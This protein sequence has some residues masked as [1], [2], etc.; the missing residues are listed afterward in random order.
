MKKNILIFGGEFFNKGA[1]SMSFITISRLKDRFPDHEIIFISER[2]SRR[3]ESELNNYNFTISPDPYRRNIV[4]GEN[5]I[6]RILKL[7]IRK[8]PKEIKRKLKDTEYIFDISGFALSSQFGEKYSKHYLKRFD[9]AHESGIK[10][11]ILPQSIGPFEYN[12]SQDEMIKLISDT[13]SKVEIVMPREEQGEKLLMNLGLN[14]NLHK[15]AD[16]VLTSRNKINWDNIYKVKP[17]S[18]EFAIDRDSVMI[19]PNAMNFKHGNREE[20]VRLYKLTIDELLKLNK[21]IYI[22]R[23]SAQDS[24]A[25]HILKEEYEV[26][27]KV[28]VIDEDMTPNEF[29]KLVSQF[30]FTIASRFHAIVHSYKV[31][32]PNIILGWAVKYIELAKLFNQEKY[33]FDVRDN[34][35][36]EVFIDN[37][38]YLNDNFATE[39]IEI[40]SNLTKIEELSDPFDYIFNTMR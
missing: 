34:L 14:N 15:N 27:S 11:F 2:D 1:Q 30:D 26:E 25:I 33:V 32:V 6:R 35:S 31:G 7:P 37:L 29:E 24:N 9:K 12:E 22:V 39:S 28:R 13:L 18:K 8:S 3:H 38:K 21:N 19:V 17:V 5:L 4:L 40:Q 10:S 20:I 36:E 16:L 23:H